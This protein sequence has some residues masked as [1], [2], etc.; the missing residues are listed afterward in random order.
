MLR[1]L[2][3]VAVALSLAM[4]PTLTAPR[5]VLACSC[6]VMPT[7][8][9]GWTRETLT[10]QADYVFRGT[11]IAAGPGREDPNHEN[12]GSYRVVL[13]VAEVW[14]G[15][16]RPLY[17]AIAGELGGDCSI[18]DFQAG[19]SWLVYGWEATA[20]PAPDVLIDTTICDRSAPLGDASADLHVL[21]AGIRP[22]AR[23][24]LTPVGRLPLVGWLGE[25]A[26][27]ISWL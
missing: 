5:R 20:N 17:R 10:A 23:D 19:S 7:P 8:S 22:T 25:L 12:R 14:K 1:R 3:F 11:V 13:A 15:Q 27:Y 24:S 6:A 26:Y 16:A 2:F 18:T 21:G 4:T 9:G